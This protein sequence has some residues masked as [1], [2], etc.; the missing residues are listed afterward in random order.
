MMKIKFSIGISNVL[1]NQKRMRYF[2]EY[3]FTNESRSEIRY[4]C[5]I[6]LVLFDPPPRS[7]T[8]RLNMLE[9]L[10][11]FRHKTSLR[12]HC[13][14]ILQLLADS[15]FAVTSCMCICNIR[16]VLPNACSPSTMLREGYY[17]WHIQKV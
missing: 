15:P 13:S 10:Y 7:Y 9:G 16:M 17:W 5:G 6:I 11:K 2:S 14:H 4:R 12:N 8:H 3:S 1:K